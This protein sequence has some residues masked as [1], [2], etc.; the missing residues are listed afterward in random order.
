MEELCNVKRFF[1]SSRTL[2]IVLVLSLVEEANFCFISSISAAFFLVILN[3]CSK[4][5]VLFLFFE[6]KLV[7]LLSLHVVYAAVQVL[8]AASYV[9]AR[10]LPLI[11]GEMET[12]ISRIKDN[13]ILPFCEALLLPWPMILDQPLL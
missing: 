12:K 6:I 2:L 8:L 11:N 4:T 9:R 3:T 1:N 10:L 13:I 7:A 5:D